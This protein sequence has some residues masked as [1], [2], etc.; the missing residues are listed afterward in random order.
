MMMNLNGR[1]VSY[2]DSTNDAVMNEFSTDRQFGCA[3]PVISAAHGG[4]LVTAR[5]E[6][7]VIDTNGRQTLISNI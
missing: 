1:I 5:E 7:T 2:H 4:I 3:S 6:W